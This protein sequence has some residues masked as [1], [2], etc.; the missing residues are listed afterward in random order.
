MQFKPMTKKELDEMGLLPDGFYL[1]EVTN[2]ENAVSRAGKEMI[3]LTLKI[4][5]MNGRQRILSDYLLES[6]PKKLFAFCESNSMLDKYDTGTLNAHDCVGKSGQVHIKRQ[7][8]NMKPD[9]T[10]YPDQNS[11]YDYLKVDNHKESVVKGDEFQDDSIP[12]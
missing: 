3:K 5:D 6:M 8:G 4:W 12:F 10:Q 1:Y 2:A 11:V 7:K 9:G